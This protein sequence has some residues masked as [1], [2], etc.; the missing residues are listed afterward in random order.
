M[1]KLMNLK[2][3]KYENII[4]VRVIIFYKEY[5]CTLLEIYQI[6]DRDSF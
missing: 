5:F 6:N 2:I 1:Q 3:L 4:F